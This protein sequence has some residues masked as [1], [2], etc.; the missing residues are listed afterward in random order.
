MGVAGKPRV[1]VVDDD[2]TTLEILSAFF[3]EKGYE[4]SVRDTALGT[5]ADLLTTAPDVVV[6]DV[7]MPGISG[8]R[9][10][11]VLRKHHATVGL[12]I[13][14]YSS[15]P[16]ADLQATAQG[17]QPATYVTKSQGPRALLKAVESF[18]APRAG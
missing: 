17:V 1:M 10:A 14:L 7:T 11:S 3:E 6:L 18:V 2:R 4:V 5:S 9:I 12:P 13:V 16:E 8:D 15:A